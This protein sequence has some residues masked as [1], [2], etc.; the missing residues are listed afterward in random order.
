[1]PLIENLSIRSKIAAAP[2]IL[3][4]IL[5]LL[6]GAAF[7]LLTGNAR[8]VEA[9]EQEVIA[10]LEATQKF[11]GALQQVMSALFKLTSVAAN[12]SDETKIARMAKEVAVKVKDL[13]G[14]LAAVETALAGS[15]VG[16]DAVPDIKAALAKFAKSATVVAEMADTD[17][18]MSLTMMSP[19]ERNYQATTQVLG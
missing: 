5:C 6:G 16:A 8:D 4:L 1:M 13:D 2:A 17:A 7:Q 19:T 14:G 3:L 15:P 12:E 11:D 10:R 9:L 18:G